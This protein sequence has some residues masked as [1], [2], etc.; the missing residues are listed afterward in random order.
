MKLKLSTNNNR[1]IFETD[2]SITSIWIEKNEKKMLVKQNDK[3]SIEASEILNLLNRN[4]E[5]RAK[6]FYNTKKNS[7]CEEFFFDE[8]LILLVDSPLTLEIN[9]EL[10]S[11]YVTLDGYLRF[12]SNQE[13]SAS[14][15][16][17]KSILKKINS[18][19]DTVVIELDVV[20]KFLPISSASLIIKN[21]KS[22]EFE[23]FESQTPSSIIKENTIYT[24]LIYEINISKLKTLL[25]HQN[26]NGYDSTV[27]DT[28]VSPSF[29]YSKT[30]IRQFKI[31]R[32]SN[33]IEENWFNTSGYY[34]LLKNYGTQ[35]FNNL[36]FRTTFLDT[37]AFDY[38]QKIKNEEE[39]TK[40]NVKK[41]ILISEYPHK[42]QDN[43]LHL[44]NYLNIE[45]KDKFDC[46]YIINKDSKDIKNLESFKK[47]I[48]TFKSKEHFEIIL[49][50]DMILHTHSSNYA[51]PLITSFMESYYKDIKKIF[52]Q[53]G[54]I[55]ERN[56]AYLYGKD[57]N[58]TFTDKFI[59]S[60]IREKKIVEKE[61]GYAPEDILL[62]GLARFDSLLE[63]NS[64]EKSFNLKNNILIMP[65]WRQGED[66]LSDNEFIKTDFYKEFSSLLNNPKFISMIEK[67]SLTV[68]F[69]LHTNF[70]KYH[71]LFYSDFISIIREG[72]DSVQ[73][74]LK[75]NGV[76][77]TDFSSVGLDFSL[78]DR[79]VLYY[80]FDTSLKESRKQKKNFL[81]G[82]IIKNQNS[83]LRTIEKKI[84][85]NNLSPIYKIFRKRNLYYYNDTNAKKRIVDEILK[86][87]K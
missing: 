20:T 8:Q 85:K 36:A 49:K 10:I 81:P 77:I 79:P 30:T 40:K 83:L 13:P 25:D 58:P 15:Y 86:L 11:L 38:Y 56:L 84:K 16:F 73:N 29:Q 74:L 22:K 80:Q 4:S 51:L 3:F 37:S 54:I 27:L 43:G 34:M 50:A 17:K 57:T 7:K 5:D 23:T 18:T 24:T 64:T 78:L 61:L 19:K 48:I 72:D 33:F 71:H 87:L 28:F 6:I 82:P 41:I 76:L 26:F 69:Y 65:S 66:S 59:V 2:S 55:G 68:S 45:H 47:Q 60:S 12:I 14:S 39:S 46:F 31:E 70:Q 67:Y 1:F 62:T 52:L 21:R 35:T 44:F 75:N 63:G 32:P 9:D 42:A 53:H